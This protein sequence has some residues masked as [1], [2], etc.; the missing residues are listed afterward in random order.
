M[1]NVLKKM[2]ELFCTYL[3]LDSEIVSPNT[4][5]I[6]KGQLLVTNTVSFKRHNCVQKW[7]EF[8]ATSLNKVSKDNKDKLGIAIGKAIAK[9]LVVSFDDVQIEREITDA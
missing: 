9:N 6:K 1:K 4:V 2:D 8:N 3:G 7:D 5:E